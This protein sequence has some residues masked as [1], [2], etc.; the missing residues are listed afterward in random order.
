MNE[1]FLLKLSE[2]EEKWT[3]FNKK[4]LLLIVPVII[5]VVL[6]FFLINKPPKKDFEKMINELTTAA[7]NKCREENFIITIAFKTIVEE[8]FDYRGYIPESGRIAVSE[9]CEVAFELFDNGQCVSKYFSDKDFEIKSSTREK[10]Y[11]PKT[12]F[13]DRRIIDKIIE[14]YIPIATKEELLLIEDVNLNIFGKGT[15]FES[16]YNGGVEKKYM[17]LNDINL[18]NINFVPIGSINQ[19]FTGIIDGN[20]YSIINLKINQSLN[21]DITDVDFE[22]FGR[23]IGL[24]RYI[25]GGII[26]NI[27]LDIN[28]KAVE[29]IGGFAGKAKN[30]KFTNATVSGK[31]V[32]IN[33]MG[34]FIGE[35]E[36]VSFSK[37]A[38]LVSVEGQGLI[39]GFVGRSFETNFENSYSSANLKSKW[40]SAGFVGYLEKGMFSNC[41]SVANGVGSLFNHFTFGQNIEYKNSYYGAEVFNVHPGN[42]GKSLIDLKKKNTYENWDFETIWMIEEGVEYPVLR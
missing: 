22:T 6:I 30:T 39:G 8:S 36:N 26:N 24:F 34:G 40:D 11:M 27:N 19:P 5:I 38:S 28:I 42:M 31:I 14:G 33:I 3:N 29:T 32:G 13:E 4:K 18:E 12:I 15:E 2:L 41:Y 35:G 1:G 37:T 21:N 7:Q 10:C 20:G 17:L 25:E 16:Q 23:N 9:G